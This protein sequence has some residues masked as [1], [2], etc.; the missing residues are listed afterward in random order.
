MNECSFIVIYIS[1]IYNICTSTSCSPVLREKLIFPQTLKKFPPLYGICKLITALKTAHHF[2]V[3]LISSIQAM[4]PHPTSW[5]FILILFFHVRVVLSSGLLPQVFPPKQTLYI[6][7]Y[8]WGKAMANY[9]QELAQDAACQSHTG[10]MTGLWFLSTRPLRLNT[11][12]WMNE[13]SSNFLNVLKPEFQKTNTEDL[14]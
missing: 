14:R 11:N 9:P 5:R 4:P 1:T 10:H 2:S 3:S 12:E 8:I 6:Y 13:W 7:I